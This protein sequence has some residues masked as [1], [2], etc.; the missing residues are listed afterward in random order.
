MKQCLLISGSALI[1][2][3]RSCVNTT[4]EERKVRKQKAEV[5]SVITEREE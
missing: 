3:V 5:P 2:T 4:A 1:P